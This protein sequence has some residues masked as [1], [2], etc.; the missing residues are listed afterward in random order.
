MDSKDNFN[1]LLVF[2]FEVNKIYIEKVKN[3]ISSDKMNDVL[4]L[5][6]DKELCNYTSKDILTNNHPLLNINIDN[7]NIDFYI[8][9]S[10]IN[11]NI[12]VRLIETII[13]SNPRFVPETNFLHGILY[14][15]F[16]F[17][18]IYNFSR[19]P[20]NNNIVTDLSYYSKLFTVYKSPECSR[21]GWAY[22]TLFQDILSVLKKEIIIVGIPIP[23]K[24]ENINNVGI[25]VF[26]INKYYTP[27]TIEY[28]LKY[29]INYAY[30]TNSYGIY[31][32]KMSN[33]FNINNYSGRDKLDIIC[34]TIV[35]SNNCIP[36]K[37]SLHPRYNII[38]TL[39]ASMHIH[40]LG[41]KTRAN[42]YVNITSKEKNNEW[43]K[44][45]YLNNPL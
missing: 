5:I 18:N 43:K 7:N 14:G 10:Y 21:L 19:L 2:R 40:L 31:K 4:S 35:S 27:S 9:H 42:I 38:E 6:D 20:K 17:K 36:G 30:A 44:L 23:F 33:V 3:N 28:I 41:D 29:N 15:L 26:G 45:K 16:N 1:K 8:D 24:K 32:Q 25:I 39:Y 34:N 13:G 37:L 22:Y 12:L 11:S